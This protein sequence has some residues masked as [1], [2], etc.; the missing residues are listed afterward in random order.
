MKQNRS[1]VLTAGKGKN[2]FDQ[3]SELT[4][5][6]PVKTSIKSIDQAIKRFPLRFRKYATLTSFQSKFNLELLLLKSIPE[7][8]HFPTYSK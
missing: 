8:V 4:R 6:D 3:K 5:A 1:N 2:Y 7:S